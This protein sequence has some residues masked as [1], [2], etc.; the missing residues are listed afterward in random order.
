[1]LERAIHGVLPDGTYKPP[2]IPHS[3]RHKTVN[4]KWEWL[5]AHPAR[6]ATMAVMQATPATQPMACGTLSPSDR[7]EDPAVQAVVLMLKE[8]GGSSA[9]ARKSTPFP[10]ELARR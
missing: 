1:M 7:R 6:T 2:R 8:E 3:A 9:G 10:G 4:P 5:P